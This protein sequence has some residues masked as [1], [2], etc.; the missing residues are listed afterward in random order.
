MNYYLYI[1]P[2]TLFF[3]KKGECLF[4]NTLN[5]KA[6]KIDVSND[7]YFIL[8][9]LETDKYIILSDENLQTQ[10]V[11]FWVNRLRETFNV[12][13]FQ[14]Q[15]AFCNFSVCFFSV[16]FCCKRKFFFYFSS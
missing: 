16:F 7:M 11:S 12:I 9:E 10:T 1:E 6:L 13:F 4:Y 3:R 14:F 2:Y 15:N 5:K 8:D